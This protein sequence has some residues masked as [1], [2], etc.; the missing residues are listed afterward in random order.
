MELELEVEESQMADIVFAACCEVWRPSHSHSRVSSAA[1]SVEGEISSLLAQSESLTEACKLSCDS[2]PPS[3]DCRAPGK[4][5]G[6]E[7]IDSNDRV[8]P[9]LSLF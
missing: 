8:P 2:G 1:R 9:P 6:I 4:I 5:K 3:S 7:N